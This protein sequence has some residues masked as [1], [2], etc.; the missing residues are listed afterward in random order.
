MNTRKWFYDP[1]TDVLVEKTWLNWALPFLGGNEY[2][3]LCTVFADSEEEARKIVNAEFGDKPREPTEYE[4][5]LRLRVDE[6]LDVIFKYGQIDG[7]HHKT[8]V[9]DQVVRLL[10]KEAYQKWIEDY[11]ED[12]QYEWD[13]GITP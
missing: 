5:D 1:E 12:G 8:W 3:G 7:E 10:T 11:C 6:V 13:E 2:E 9:I 4:K